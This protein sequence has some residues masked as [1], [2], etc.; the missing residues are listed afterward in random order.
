MEKWKYT[1]HSYAI[2]DTGDYESYVQFTNGKEILQSSADDMTD[3]DVLDFCK[4]LNQM[5]DL[6]SLSLDNTSFMKS[7]IEKDKK[8]FKDTL[9]SILDM[10]DINDIKNLVT[11]T[12]SEEEIKE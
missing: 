6:R 5:D 1:E 11:N 4:L 2:A 10:D 7:M 8:I 3:Q 9:L 12:L